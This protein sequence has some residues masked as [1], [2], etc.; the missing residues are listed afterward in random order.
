VSRTNTQWITYVLRHGP[1][2]YSRSY[3]VNGDPS[4]EV[5]LTDDGPEMC[6]RAALEL[7][8][9]D[10]AVCVATALPRTGQTARLLLADRSLPVEVEPRL[11]EIDYGGF[12]GGEFNSYGDWLAVNGGWAVPPGATESQR[13]ALLR[14][15]TALR[16]LL[17]R[18]GP[19][20]VVGHGLMLSVLN[21]ARENPGSPLREVFFPEGAYLTP[22]ILADDELGLLLDFLV[23][24]LTASFPAP[25]LP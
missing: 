14:M 1:T 16:D 23:E 4:S 25:A 19:R 18:P 21:W 3:R 10:F 15:F 20:L 11:N 9:D 17:S 2:A 5:L 22:L 13:G 7:P 8:M 6:T 24:D 12:E